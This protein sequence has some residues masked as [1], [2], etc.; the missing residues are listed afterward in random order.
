MRTR[1]FRCREYPTPEGIH[2][3][4]GQAFHPLLRLAMTGCLKAL[5][6]LPYAMATESGA[7]MPC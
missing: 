4:G 2:A 1:Q 7:W 3:S 5:T 6:V